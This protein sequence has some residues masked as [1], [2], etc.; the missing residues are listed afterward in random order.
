MIVQPRNR[1][2][3]GC[4]DVPRLFAA[5]VDW[6]SQFGRLHFTL[7]SREQVEPI[8]DLRCEMSRAEW[9]AFRDAV[10]A[11]YARVPFDDVTYDE[12]GF[13]RELSPNNGAR[14]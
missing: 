4:P 9:V 13:Q 2:T 5:Q 10:D 8:V 14:T 11:E 12:F 7:A 3:C 1:T 6:T